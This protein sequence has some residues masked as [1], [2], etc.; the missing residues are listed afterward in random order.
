MLSVLYTRK[1]YRESF[2]IRNEPFYS[3]FKAMQNNFAFIVIKD[4]E[5]QPYLVARRISKCARYLERY[6]LI[7]FSFRHSLY[8]HSSVGK[9]RD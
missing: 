7:I 2:I 4:G 3:S 8:S 6:A 1:S 9:T 5:T